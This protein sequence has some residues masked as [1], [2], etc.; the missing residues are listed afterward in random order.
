MNVR[1]YFA[2]V[3]TIRGYFAEVPA[4]GGWEN[5][6]AKNQTSV[7]PLMYYGDKT[8]FLGLHIKTTYLDAFKFC[9]TIHMN[10]VSV[11]TADENDRLYKYVRDAN[12]GDNFWTAGSRL[13]DG[14]TWIW[15]SN[16]E[17]VE[18]TNWAPG[19]PDSEGER[20]L[21][22]WHFRN[23]GLLWNDRDCNVHFNFICERDSKQNY[24]K[25]D[26]SAVS[27][28]TNI[29]Q[30]PSV[31]PSI[32]LLFYGEKSYYISR[33]LRATFLQATQFCNIIQMQL[34]TITSDDENNRLHKYI[35]DTFAGD[36]F[37][38]SGSRSLDGK[39]WTWMSTGRNVDYTHWLPGQPDSQH[40]N[41]IQLVDQRNNGLFWNDLGCDAQIPFIC[42]KSGVSWEST[43]FIEPRISVT[44]KPLVTSTATVSHTQRNRYSGS[45][46]LDNTWLNRIAESTNIPLRKIHGQNYHLG[47]SF[48]ANY[49][50]ATQFCQHHLMQLISV[51]SEKNNDVIG[52]LLEN[53]DPNESYW[54][55]GN[56]LSDGKTWT[57]A[58]GDPIKNFI[59]EHSGY[60]TNS[61][62]NCLE[63]NQNLD[64]NDQNCEEE[65]YFICEFFSKSTNLQC[66]GQQGV[67]VYINNNLISQD[68]EITRNVWSKNLTSSS[69]QG[70]NVQVNTNIDASK[71]D[72]SVGAKKYPPFIQPQPLDY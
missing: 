7:L 44:R 41:C 1:G 57:W 6:F 40:E 5:V 38:S 49:F 62:K 56:K 54:I 70:Y 12:K 67:N 23:Q 29:F 8:Y 26:D 22:L 13:L 69:A 33:Y 27:G 4:S 24:F 37:W 66:N 34:V 30:H 61:H 17:P 9:R 72:E 31:S 39:T 20:C 63:I 11:K 50:Q 45:L 14:K 46:N 47:D 28:W 18:Y 51:N 48:K 60:N 2:E 35:R 58:T 52:S 42:E 15:M 65:R 64:W 36:S 59:P 55:S 19:Q 32:N 25:Q 68:G 21:E 71:Q 16:G 53:S 10:L 3:P 43:G